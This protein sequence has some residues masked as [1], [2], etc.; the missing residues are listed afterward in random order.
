MKNQKGIKLIALV[1]TIVVLLILAGTAIAMLQ[2]DNGIISNAQKAQAANTE[3]E[4]LD[5]IRLAYNTINTIVLSKT[6]TDPS[7]NPQSEAVE[8]DLAQKVVDEMGL[9]GTIESGTAL[10][11]NTNGTGYTILYTKTNGGTPGTIV[12]TYAD[13]TF[14]AD[15]EPNTPNKISR[16]EITLTIESNRVTMS[17]YKTQVEY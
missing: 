16:I 1:V 4:V 7:Y 10:K 5:K 17:S 2:G 12:I 6:S 11:E 14:K 15:V 9:T 3:G 8:K 13:S